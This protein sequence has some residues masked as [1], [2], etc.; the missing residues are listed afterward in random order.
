MP[1]YCHVYRS[2]GHKQENCK[3]VA[4][5]RC[6][7][8]HPVDRGTKQGRRLNSDVQIGHTAVDNHGVTQSD[9]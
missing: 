6:E 8:D 4:L 7:Y 9:G 5:Q 3:K 1:H 2:L